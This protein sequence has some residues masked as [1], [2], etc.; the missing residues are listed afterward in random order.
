[1]M[2]TALVPA[3]LLAMFAIFAPKSYAC[4]CVKDEVPQAYDE[5]KA[6]FIGEVTEI[7]QPRTDDQN[8]DISENLFV[9]KFKVERSWK[10]AGYLDTTI[11]EIKILSDQGR[12]GCFSWGPFLEGRKYLVYAVQTDGDNLAVLFSCNRTTPISDA[13]DDLKVLRAMESPFF[14][15]ERKPTFLE[16]DFFGDPPGK[17]LQRTGTK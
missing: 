4:F 11:A 8:A 9:I 3:V 14:K 16:L 5:A 15:F 6:V 12:A 7:V 10:G 13:A 2:K 1:M 17:R